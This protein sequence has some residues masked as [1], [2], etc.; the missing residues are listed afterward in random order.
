MGEMFDKP[1]KRVPAALL[2]VLAIAVFATWPGIVVRERSRPDDHQA[3]HTAEIIQAASAAEDR[4]DRAGAIESLGKLPADFG[5]RRV[6]RAWLKMAEL[7]R[8]TAHLSDAKRTLKTIVENV[9]GEV[10]A[11]RRLAEL[12]AVCGYAFE[13]LAPLR[14]LLEAGEVDEYDLFRLA[15]NG[16]DLY[17]KQTLERNYAL[18]PNDPM[19]VAGLL[20][21]AE[22]ERDAARIDALLAR[23]LPGDGVLRRI[24]LQRRL[25]H[26]NA[27]DD[28]NKLLSVGEQH[29]ESWL[30]AA[31]A[32]QQ[33]GDH[34]TTLE[35]A[36][37]AVRL[38]PWNQPA[39]HRI[40]NLLRGRQPELEERVQQLAATL[41][42][43]ER[44]AR[45]IRQGRREGKSYQTLG[46]LLISIGRVREGKGWARVAAQSGTA[47]AWAAET[48][49]LNN[50]HS[51]FVHP[52]VAEY[53]ATLDSQ[54][55]TIRIRRP[56][57]K[58]AADERE[59]DLAF[60]NVASGVGIEFRY[61][62]GQEPDQQGLFMHQWTG[63]GVGVLDIDGDTWPDLL[64]TQGGTLR[65][66]QDS[67]PFGDVI[68]R[69]R[70]G[71]T[72]A[73]VTPHAAVNAVGG[74][75]QGTA[76]GDVNN[77]GFDDVYIGRVGRNLLL[78]NQGDGTFLPGEQPST[79]SA[80]T[81]SAAIADLNGDGN[82]DI[83]DV[84]YLSGNDAFTTT[85]DHGGEQRICG[86]T[87]F[88]AA[89][90][91]VSWANGDGTFRSEGS[92][93]TTAPQAGM[94][95]VVG[96]FVDGTPV[97]AYIA[98]D[99]AANQLLSFGAASGVHDSAPRA[100][101][102]FGKDGTALG[103]MGIAIADVAGDGTADVF[104]TNYYSEPNNLYAQIQPNVFMDTASYSGL[105]AACYSML[106][107]GCQFADFDADGDP[108]L[109]VSNGHLDDFTH[110][111]RPYRMPAQLFANRGD[112]T[113]RTSQTTGNYFDKNWLGRAV[114]LLDWNG[115]GRTDFAVTHLD[116]GVGL[117][118]NLSP[119]AADSL[120]ISLRGTRR[121]RDAV[122]AVMRFDRA[123][124]LQTQWI[125]AGDGYQCSNQKVGRFANVEGADRG[126]VTIQWPGHAETPIRV[127]I[128]NAGL[129]MVIEGREQSYA[130]PR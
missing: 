25:N 92:F 28:V 14:Q 100:G 26:S 5:D 123:S 90:D 62:N 2:V 117:V 120:T 71:Q 110:L 68:Y 97:Q 72:F 85:C 1:Q 119:Q 49:S 55:T 18:N 46:A 77:D 65:D 30:I 29:P 24:A 47:L 35:C 16:H 51:E 91:A 64:F 108:D 114:A 113:F 67:P 128:T 42:K 94:G 58:A 13:A 10:T 21:L 53:G 89:A 7:Q 83:Y 48:L 61:D 57:E 39:L 54:S 122:G 34:E 84:N 60:D 98:N 106:G 112:G 127:P 74:F 52:V 17:G 80:W 43:I 11:R 70:R 37:Q 15:V 23:P 96:R 79:T 88:P 3:A 36:V 81:T 69:N 105:S 45:Q 115:D 78:I 76:V 111:N 12:L 27:V 73:D 32:S 99:E 40:A 87:D 126:E 116:D 6:Y 4:G 8:R 102:A 22:S 124:T 93:N 31:E 129:Q 86:P 20:R 82:P 38:D 44:L 107:F 130:V 125:T 56:H 121:G 109:V 50:D 63:G 101:L 95:L 75:G 9:D 59:D 118:E 41:D 104:V 103:S 33:T 66:D 19:A